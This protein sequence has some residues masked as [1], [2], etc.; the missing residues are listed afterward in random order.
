MK[1]FT[2][3]L[4]YEASYQV[5][6]ARRHNRVPSTDYSARALWLTGPF[7][8]GPIPP[9]TRVRQAERWLLIDDRERRRQATMAGA[10]AR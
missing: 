4:A 1:A 3:L 10:G 7:G 6:R 2:V 9:E 8:S 5:W